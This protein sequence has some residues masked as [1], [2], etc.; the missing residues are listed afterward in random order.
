VEGNLDFFCDFAGFVPFTSQLYV[1][2]AKRWRTMDSR[3]KSQIENIKTL[4]GY[5]PDHY[6]RFSLFHELAK[7]N[8]D[9]DDALNAL[10]HTP[11]LLD[12]LEHNSVPPK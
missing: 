12:R 11:G 1:D 10:K 4:L 9:F 5:L 7:G 8:K 6:M 2:L 3:K